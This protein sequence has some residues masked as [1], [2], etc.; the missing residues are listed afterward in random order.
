MHRYEPKF[1]GLQKISEI[2]CPEG[3][4]YCEESF[5]FF[6][7][8]TEGGLPLKVICVVWGYFICFYPVLVARDG[9][10]IRLGGTI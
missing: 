9:I 8:V 4:P 6:S 2:A 5:A 10:S 1:K 3:K 7:E